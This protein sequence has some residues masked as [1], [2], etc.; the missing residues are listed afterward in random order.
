[1]N[2]KKTKLNSTQFKEW[3]TNHKRKFFIMFLTALLLMASTYAW[4]SSSLNVKIQFLKLSVASNSGLFISLDGIDFSDSIV[5]SM[6][7][8]IMDLKETYPNHTN[9]WSYGLW[10]VSTN[11]IMDSDQDKFEVFIGDLVHT[12]ER[13]PNGSVKRLLNTV[14]RNEDN[15]NPG[16]LY[17][18]F[19]VFF[20]NDTGSPFA[21]NLYFADTTT[22]DYAEDTEEE[23]KAE[24]DGILNTIRL[25][26]IKVGSVP[27]NSTPEEIQNM[28]CNNSCEMLIYE[29]YSE[30]HSEVS[31]ETALNY[32]IM[33][34]D[35]IEIPSYAIIAEGRRLEHTN[36]HIGTGIPLDTEHFKM[37]E[38]VKNF[39]KPVFEVPNAITKAR[40]YIWLEGQDIDSLETN[41]KGV[42]LT[43]A[44]DFV[45]DLA[46]YE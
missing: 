20:K 42:D 3:I 2:N 19:D 44:I 27:L 10:P 25:G 13:N 22:I 28:K 6:D 34:V 45:K 33:I 31:I 4:L 8:T 39:T 14:R 1:M 32:G 38:T 40:I 5:I 7:S 35:G 41:S 26:I 21:D 43:V 17:V 23:L 29:P 46:G 15:P 12:K 36:G 30:S 16:N 11:G 9:Q 24:M 37:Q 18:A